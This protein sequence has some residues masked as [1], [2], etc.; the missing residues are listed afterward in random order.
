MKKRTIIKIVGL[1]LCVLFFTLPLV[2]CSQD[3]SINAT[4]WE[5]ATGT[6]DLFE[7]ADNSDWYP[8]I[9]VLLVIPGLLLG[10]DLIPGDKIPL[11][12]LRY[13]SI[14]GL[15]TQIIF[16]IIA[17]NKLNDSQGAFV[18]TPYNWLV[19]AIYAGII[20]FTQYCIKQGTD[21]TEG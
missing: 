3:S 4:G 19:I 5:I 8:L 1:V 7:N 9:I 13:I 6:G 20:G 18:L 15:A 14:A 17:Y 12:A 21:A 10:C 2:Q 16:M 11:P